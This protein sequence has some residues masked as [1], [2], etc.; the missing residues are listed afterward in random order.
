METASLIITGILAGL[1]FWLG[2]YL[3]YRK[4]KKILDGC[5]DRMIVLDKENDRLT[6]EV[7]KYRGT[8]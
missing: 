5:K 8:T 2:Y 6:K 4:H 3:A 1:L 7:L